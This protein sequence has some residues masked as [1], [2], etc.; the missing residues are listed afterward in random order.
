MANKFT[1]LFFTFLLL[2]GVCV[3]AQQKPYATHTPAATAVGSQTLSALKTAPAS[4]GGGVY[5]PMSG[6]DTLS[7]ID[8]GIDT[9][10]VYTLNAPNWGYAGGT[11]SFGDIAKAEYYAYTGPAAQITDIIFG[12]GRA[13]AASASSTIQVRVWADNAGVPGAVLHTQSLSL[14]TCATNLALGLPT[15]VTLSTPV[16]IT[17]GFFVGFQFGYAPGDTIAIISNL[18]NNTPAPGTAW[19][20]WNTLAWYPYS[21]ATSSWGINVSNFILPVVCPLS[22]GPVAG[23]TANPTTICVGQQVQFT[24]TSTGN[25][26]NYSWSFPG[27]TPAT[28]TA[29][30]PVVTYSTVGSYGATLIAYDAT[31]ASNTATQN[32]LITVS[33]CAPGCDTLTNIDFGI[34]TLALFTVGGTG[35]WGYVSGHNNYGDISKADFYNY[36]GPAVQLTGILF[37]FGKGTAANANSNVQVRVWANNAGTP[38]AVLASQNLSLQT[39]AADVA[40]GNITSVTLTNPVNITGPFFAGITFAYAP[41]DTVALITNRNNNTPAPGTAWEQWD[42][43]AW[44]AYSNTNSWGLN[45]SHFILPVLCTQSGAAPVA[46]FTANLTTICQGNQIQFTS[47]STGSPTGYQWQFPGGTPATSTSPNPTVTYGTPGVYSVILYASNAFGTGSEVKTNFITVNACAGAPVANFSSNTQ[48]ICSG[49]SV[50]F[51]NLSSGSPTS[52]QWSFPGGT[53]ASS[54]LDNPIVNYPAP[55]VYSVVLVASNANGSNASSQVNYVTVNPSPIAAFSFNQLGNGNVQFVNNSTNSPV[56][57]S[58]TFQGGNPATSTQTNP[59]VSYGQSGVYTVVLTA[60]NACGQNSTTQ[61]I[62]ITLVAI[63]PTWENL[64]SIYPN[65]NLGQ[66]TIE[67]KDEALK[68]FTLNLTDIQGKTVYQRQF[69]Q[70]QAGSPIQIDLPGLAAGTY[71]VTLTQADKTAHFKMLIEK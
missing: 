40:A 18:N 49:Q 22:T 24:N 69:E 10:T 62:E 50:S 58:W 45:V 64:I 14:Q 4:Q 37:G 17:G 35:N 44:Y 65:P 63:D 48:L 8:F 1:F 71:F 20:Q 23:F 38:G 36:S 11:N 42:T 60:T 67:L 31:G 12:F 32:N 57:Y 55:G 34:D 39:I 29:A 27:G 26:T 54:T 52:Y 68:D 66:F 59:A 13:S 28:S 43:Q 6:C 47:T 51:Y 7:N 53:P 5:M 56:S 61:Q 2:V 41:G 9:L 25:P 46:N 3:H 19:E 21:N 16:N 30:N 70:V 15:A 33:A